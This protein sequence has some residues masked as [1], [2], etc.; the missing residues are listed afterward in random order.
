MSKILINENILFIS[1][2]LFLTCPLF[3]L[4]WWPPEGGFIGIG[5]EIN[6]HTREGLA[7]GGGLTLGIDLNE[8]FTAGLRNSFF[9]NT[10]T[11]GAF[12]ILGIFRYYLPWLHLPKSNDGPFVQAEIGAVFFFEYGH[13]FPS[14][15][16]GLAAG[17]RFNLGELFYIEP[18]LRGGY[19]HFWGLSVTAGIKFKGKRESIQETIIEYVDREVIVE[20]ETIVE[21]EIEPVASVPVLSLVYSPKIFSPDGDGVNDVIYI[22]LSALD[23]SPITSWYVEIRD[24]ETGEIFNRVE[25]EGSPPDELLWDGFDFNGMLM[26]AFTDYPYTYVVENIHGNSASLEG[27]LSIKEM[28]VIYRNGRLVIQVPSIVFRADHADYAG[29]S[30]ENLSSNENAFRIAATITKNLS[31]YRL[32]VEGHAN[33]TTQEGPARE[34]ENSSLTTLSEQRAQAV[35]NELVRRGVDRSRITALGFGGTNTLFPWTDSENVWRNRRVEFILEKIENEKTEEE[36]DNDQL[37][38]IN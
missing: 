17:W 18:A 32:I 3:A 21:K 35:V 25:G 12:E 24:P 20:R 28:L 30:A 10:D 31:G 34:R 27:I 4:D 8:Y 1:L 26:M 29:L 22:G 14:F 15:S 38:I 16:G 23:T 2:L 19:P 6:A 5:P 33:P 37:S 7:I 9:H 36:E 13:A 11:V